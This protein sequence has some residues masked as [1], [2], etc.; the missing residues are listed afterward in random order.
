MPRA[1]ALRA[2]HGT[3]RP[4][5]LGWGAFIVAALLCAPA[6]ADEPEVE[7]L[8]A[9]EACLADPA[10]CADLPEHRPLGLA[11]R[12]PMGDPAGYRA[13]GLLCQ[14]HDDCS[15]L[16]AFS[17]ARCA[18]QDPEGCATLGTLHEGGLLED[19]RPV[20]AAALFARACAFG[21]ED[22]CRFVGLPTV[23]SF[24]EALDAAP[25]PLDLVDPA[26]LSLLLGACDA[27]AAD[28]CL[29][30]IRQLDAEATD[31]DRRS[32]FVRLLDREAERG[33]VSASDLLRTL[34]WLDDPLPAHLWA[35]ASPLADACRSDL[36]RACA[37]GRAILHLERT[38]GRPPA[39]P[40]LLADTVAEPPAAPEEESNRWVELVLPVGAGASFST[41][42][43]LLKLGFGVRAGWGVFALSAVLG[44]SFDAT[45]E[46]S[47]TGYRRVVASLG[48]GAALP[49]GPALRLHL[50]GGLGLGSRR[51]LVDT[52]FAIGP[53]EAVELSWLIKGRTGPTLG[54]RV[55][56]H[57]AWTP[58]AVLDVTG[59]VEAV[60][61][62]RMPD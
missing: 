5:P 18:L 20:V 33:R 15:G 8:Q 14:E 28:A 40:A 44:A 48:V 60:F 39:A 11:L 4:C 51:T 46:P 37:L 47:D 16:A 43:P 10:A 45:Q 54:F 17:A 49:L 26:P 1:L 3:P 36:P 59:A 35:V 55:S 62:L 58:Q 2:S 19:P 30:L 29:A 7:D 6:Q 57:Q 38:S 27:G 61:G 50:D 13:Y 52:E 56:S 24:G 22:H 53:R 12:L 21:S 23:R 31:P 9:V 32:F 42:T 41:A 34:R 25:P